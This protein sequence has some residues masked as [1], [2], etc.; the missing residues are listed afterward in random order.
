MEILV[1]KLKTNAF[2]IAALVLLGSFVPFVSFAARVEMQENIP[3]Q[4][5]FDLGPASFSLELSPGETAKQLLQV[6]NREGHTQEYNVEVEDF[7]GGQTPQEQVILRRNGTGKYSAK[8]WIV[9]ELKSFTLQHGER[10]YF[11]VDVN[12]PLDA[13]AGDHYAAVIVSRAG[14]DLEKKPSDKT[15]SEVEISSRVGTLFFIKVRG[16]EK[17]SGSLEYFRTTKKL[18][19]DDSVIFQ[20]GFHNDGTVRLQPQG[21]IEVRNMF[22]KVETIQIDP[23]NVL[24]DSFRQVGAVWQPTLGMGRYRARLI[25]NSGFGTNISQQEIVFWVI[26][27]KTILKSFSILLFV[28]VLVYFLYR[29]YGINFSIRKKTK[30]VGKIE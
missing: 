5:V 19:S 8:D 2:F 6:T 7:E 21:R 1:S 14:S 15:D 10:Q 16:D 30:D 26:S 18:Y 17:Q 9:P 27:W 4:G 22:G 11:E 29:N 25:F 23:F 3:A 20:L 13:D 28:V 12:V 24:R